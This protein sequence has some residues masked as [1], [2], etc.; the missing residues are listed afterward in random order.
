MTEECPLDL[1][2]AI[3]RTCFKCDSDLM[4]D[5]DMKFHGMGKLLIRATVECQDPECPWESQ[6]TT[7]LS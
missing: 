5:F 1:S 4:G 2:S 7:S 6:Y 3:D